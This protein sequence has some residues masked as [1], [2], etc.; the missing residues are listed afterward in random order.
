[1]KFLNVAA[2]LAVSSLNFAGLAQ[3]V[4]PGAGLACTPATCAYLDAK[5]PAEARAADLVGRMTLEEKVQ[6]T[7]DRAPAIPRLDVAEYNWW[8]EA[9][10]GVA[11]DGYATVFPQAIGLAAT[12]DTTLMG[13]V[14]ETIS[15]EARAKYNQ[16]LRNG[17][18]ARYAGLTFWSPNINNF[19]DP[20]W[21][22]GQ[23][24][25]GE[26]PFLSGAMGTAFVKGMQGDDPRY[27]KVVSTPKHFA[28][29]SGPEPLRH[30]FD[31][32]VSEHDLED[33]YLPAFRRTIVEGKAVS[34]M[35]AY[36][37]VDG[38]PACASDLL[39]K[40][41][42]RSA[43]GFNGYVVSDC[44]AVGDILS[45][46]KTAVDKAHA[47]ADALRAG[48]DLDCGGTYA[49]LGEAVRQGLLTESELDRAVA[50][51]FTARMR[52]GMF[53]PPESVPFA[54]I[55]P[56]EVDSAE[57]RALA[58]Q[59]ARESVVL[60][61]NDSVLP[62]SPGSGKAR[63]ILVVGPSAET[64]ET[65][66][67]NYQG[68][69]SAP[70]PPLPG[71]RNRFGS[72]A[73]VTYAPGSTFTAEIPSPISSTYLRAGSSGDEAGL[74][75]EYF[76]NAEF[77]G[78]AKLTRVDPVVNFHWGRVAPA[79]TGLTA[80]A[81]SMRWSGRLMVPGAGQYRFRVRSARSATKTVLG[82]AG[83]FRLTVD[84]RAVADSRTAGG[85]VS[86]SFDAAGPHE[87]VLEYVHTEGRDE[88]DALSLEWLPPQAPLLADAVK[89]A[90]SADVVVA[91]VGLSPL[92]EGEEMGVHAD[93]FAGG[94]RTR[95]EL[96]EVQE[97]LLEAIGLTGKPLI[98]VLMTGSAVASPWAVENSRAMLCAWY[99]GEVG[100]DAIA[101]VLDGSYNPAGRLPVTFYRSTEELP[102]FEDYS[103]K[104]RT[105]RYFSGPV[106]FPFGFGLSYTRFSYSAPVV[107]TAEVRAG[108]SVEVRATV[109]NAGKVEGDE[110]AELYVFPPQVEGAPLLTLQGFTRVHLK[111]GER[112]EVVFQ[113]DPRAL[114]LVDAKGERAV[115]AGEYGVGIGG[116]IDAA[117]VNQA[118][119]R[120][121]GTFPLPK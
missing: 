25:Y 86:L 101:E 74:R 40:E 73:T 12:W 71:I 8:N 3:S 18:H 104:G 66:E 1:M 69:P 14:A 27:L 21:G 115:V 60:L 121:T 35:C 47:A 15:T 53:D 68:T 33:T 82:D 97:R 56:T 28:V 85:E 87:L 17:S 99:P 114:S 34:I 37:A 52:L 102:A 78:A 110:V 5:L 108:A 38:S 100:G 120:V 2:V 84:G 112:R 61:K 67:G 11:R 42:L 16:A 44:D 91:F 105:Y 93:G 22:R 23:E 4:S 76:D 70:V 10:H 75:G 7:Q 81:F 113:L 48:T 41:H 29:H 39:L 83:H 13:R 49:A 31:V 64:L 94:D 80:T 62:L 92:L 95:I 54:K 58:L 103:M 36:N 107:A 46:H 55:P 51:L 106:L 118:K 79:G 26:D 98:T 96:P 65:L 63:R 45:G 24:T 57:H 19:R 20:R 77:Q 6:Q 109:T 72:K 30:G 59:A 111:P 9:L 89:A 90:Q 88:G 116:S 32:P 117:R 119:L 50:R 43:W